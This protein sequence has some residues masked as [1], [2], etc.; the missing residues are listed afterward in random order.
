MRVYKFIIFIILNLFPL[1]IFADGL[2]SFVISCPNLSAS[3]TLLADSKVDGTHQRLKA[4][5][6]LVPTVS[7]K[8]AQTATVRGRAFETNYG[9][10]GVIH[11]PIILM[12]E[13]SLGVLDGKISET[14]AR[15]YQIETVYEII[16]SYYE[17][18]NFTNYV[19]TLD[20]WLEFIERKATSNLDQVSVGMLQNA[21]EAVAVL[22]DVRQIKSRLEVIESKL[23]QCKVSLKPFTFP[24]LSPQ[25]LGAINRAASTTLKVQQRLCDYETQ[26]KAK[27]NSITKNGWL[28]DVRY[29]YYKTLAASGGLPSAADWS[30]SLN[31]TLPLGMVVKAPTTITN[32][33][34]EL[35]KAKQV[36]ANRSS[37]VEKDYA[38][39]IHL[40]TA[41]DRM[42]KLIA[43]IRSEA[44]KGLIKMDRILILFKEYQNINNQLFKT[45]TNIYQNAWEIVE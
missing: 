3:S 4:W 13:V 28:P 20:P 37:D 33:D 32:C 22:H 36:D 15:K 5:Q 7:L 24:N 30:L 27:E 6:S 23:R 1:V 19:K 43:M 38:N 29:S 17:W 14:K 9:V 42:G 25:Q 45:E 41:R 31:M 34:A 40:R 8:R 12:N 44:E 39:L 21:L 2:K 10:S 26:S 16:Q 11:N 18:L 35:E